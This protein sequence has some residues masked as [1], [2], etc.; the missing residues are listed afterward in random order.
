MTRD[1]RSDGRTSLVPRERHANGPAILVALLTLA[2]SGCVRH[3]APAPVT[4]AVGSGARPAPAPGQIGLAE[5]PDSIIVQPGETLYA[6]SRRYAVPLRSLIEANNLQPPFALVAG[7]R[8][9]LPQVRTY[10]VQPGDTLL[11]LS[12]R[13]GVEASTLARTNDIPPPYPVKLG[14]TLILPPPVQAA[15][16]PATAPQAAAGSPP[17]VVGEP[18]AAP[19]QSEQRPA[20]A[21]PPGSAP[22]LGEASR[23]PTAAPAPSQAQ[24]VPSQRGLPQPAQL[25]PGQVQPAPPPAAASPPPIAALP[26]PPVPVSPTPDEPMVPLPEP[27]HT[28]RGFAWPVRGSLL[29][30]YGPGANG[31]Q[32]D[33][34]NIAARAGTPVLAANDGVVA[35]AGNELRGFGNLILLKHA[36]GWTTA[37]AHCE[38]ITVRRGDRVKRGQTIARVGATGAVSEPQLHFELRR[39]TRALDP[40][41]YLPP[42]ST[43]SAG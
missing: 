43:A 41:S 14:Q 4:S 28:G 42:I 23:Q 2:L 1:Q 38:T 8:L 3:G 10:T 13:F 6:V 36:D 27:P 21:P 5:R 34:I 29:A 15:A 12:R 24:A 33:G 9:M 25:Q 18:L 17:T 40:Q 37:Y 35:Y 7:R 22:V 31:T 26:Q 16:A 20:S 39:G 11:G 32:N 19:P 30:G